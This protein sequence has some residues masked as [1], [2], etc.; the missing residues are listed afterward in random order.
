MQRSPNS[1]N[2][3]SLQSTGSQSKMFSSTSNKSIIG[4]APRTC[5]FDEFAAARNTPGPGSHNPT[6]S[7]IKPRT[8]GAICDTKDTGPK[9]KMT[10]GPG[11]YNANPVH[12]KSAFTKIGTQSRVDNFV[13]KNKAVPGP[14]NYN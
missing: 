14:A 1:R 4:N 3:N 2:K 5:Y 7:P 8:G 10:P 9:P 11:S 13:D 6:V 12:T